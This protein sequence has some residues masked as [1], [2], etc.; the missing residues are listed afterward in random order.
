MLMLPCYMFSPRAHG[1]GKMCLYDIVCM[2]S[3]TYM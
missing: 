2:M 3:Y 1:I